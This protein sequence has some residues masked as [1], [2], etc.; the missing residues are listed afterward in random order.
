MRNDRGDAVEQ[1]EGAQGSGQMGRERGNI[2][3]RD[4]RRR[5]WVGTEW[6]EGRSMGTHRYER[7]GMAGAACEVGSTESSGMQ[8]RNEHLYGERE[9]MRSVA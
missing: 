2:E 5:R 9:T 8:H 6:E 7:N 4:R 3:D 1:A